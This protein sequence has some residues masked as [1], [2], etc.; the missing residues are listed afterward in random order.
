MSRRYSHSVRFAIVAL[1]SVL[2]TLWM[3]VAFIQHQ[4][5]LAPTHHQEH[6]CQLFACAQHGA[7]AATI[8]FEDTSLPDVFASE[9]SYHYLASATF[10]YL[11]RSPPL[12]PNA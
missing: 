3:N 6:H 5:D 9:D 7:S 8:T 12:N 1:C 2:L 4:Y 10:G 11:A